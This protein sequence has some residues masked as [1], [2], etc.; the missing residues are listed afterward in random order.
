M[1]LCSL[2]LGRLKLK[3]GPAHSCGSFHA[4]NLMFLAISCLTFSPCLAAFRSLTGNGL[5]Q[6]NP[7]QLLGMLDGARPAEAWLGHHSD[8]R[9]A[10]KTYLLLAR[11][12]E[13]I[14]KPRMKMFIWLVCSFSF[15][16]TTEIRDF[17]KLTRNAFETPICRLELVTQ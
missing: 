2:M 15:H 7:S 8:R 9:S 16:P 3:V 4:S 14:V 1:T 11:S 6:E 17:P 5:R 12:G 10:R 13:G